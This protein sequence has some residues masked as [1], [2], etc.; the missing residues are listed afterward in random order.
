MEHGDGDETYKIYA[1][2]P[3]AVFYEMV[4]EAKRQNLFTDVNGKVD[5]GAL[6]AELATSFAEGKS[7]II[8]RPNAIV[9]E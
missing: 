2:I 1:T 9:I 3:K 4:R 7:K 6:V 5:I 8:S